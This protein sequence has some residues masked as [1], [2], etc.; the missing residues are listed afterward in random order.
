MHPGIEKEVCES[1]YEPPA[2]VASED[3][4]QIFGMGDETLIFNKSRISLNAP[5][6]GEAETQIIGKEKVSDVD[7]E[8]ETQLFDH[9]KEIPKVDAEAETQL[10]DVKNK[11][12]GVDTDAETQLFDTGVPDVNP[13][14]ETQLYDKPENGN[15]LKLSNG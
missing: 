13:D 6:D 12:P 15:L 4:T 3:A 10:F 1:D 7:T 2:E 5:C 9:L 14:A 11:V 8:A